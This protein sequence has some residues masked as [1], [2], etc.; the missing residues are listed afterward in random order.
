MTFKEDIAKLIRS[1]VIDE[2][3]SMAFRKLPTDI[4]PM[5]IEAM[6][7][8]LIEAV[9]RAVRGN[10]VRAAEV[11]GINR[12]TLRKKC[13]LLCISYNEYLLDDTRQYRYSGAPN[14]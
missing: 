9:L 2:I 1:L 12:N 13:R 8:P 14:C 10:Q 5:F 3:R 7:K 6:E 4:Y 11:L